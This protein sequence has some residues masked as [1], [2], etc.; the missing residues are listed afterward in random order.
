MLRS[1][2]VGSLCLSFGAVAGSALAT[3]HDVN[4]Y[5]GCIQVVDPFSA[6][7]QRLV[8]DY[9]VAYD[10]DGFWGI[11]DGTIYGWSPAEDAPICVTL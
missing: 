11:A 3:R 8:N 5:H 10:G 6:D 4:A 7:W 9:G 1:L 2:L